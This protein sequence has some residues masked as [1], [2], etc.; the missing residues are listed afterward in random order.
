LGA[1]RRKKKNIHILAEIEQALVKSG[2]LN[3]RFSIVGQ[4]GE[5]RWLNDNM[6]RPDFAGVL[7]GEA[8]ARAAENPQELWI[9]R[10]ICSSLCHPCLMGYSL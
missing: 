4:G 3:F 2:F 10:E 7:S 5:G 9:M 8:P 1:A 6:R